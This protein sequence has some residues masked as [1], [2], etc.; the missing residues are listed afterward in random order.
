MPISKQ[1]MLG[2]AAALAA[3]IALPVLAQP[4]AAPKSLLAYTPKPVK[5]PGYGRNKPV[6][7]LS[8]VLAKH[9]GQA[10]WMIIDG[11]FGVD[12][13]IE[14]LQALIKDAARKI[15]LILD[16]LRAHHAKPV[17]AWL[18]ERSDRIEVFYLPSYAPELNPDE[19][20]NADM[21]HAIG[22]KV[23]VRTKS[24]L[25]AAAEDHMT[26]IGKS[27]ERVRAYFQDPRVK[28]AA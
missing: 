25:K 17:K 7:R 4:A 6:T 5:L 3:A 13:L 11:N 1:I 2:C 18:A 8:E 21:K 22:A 27:P 28:Y 12:R 15:F 23:P 14:F 16:N 20:L 24:K 19:R 10:R 26:T 9:K